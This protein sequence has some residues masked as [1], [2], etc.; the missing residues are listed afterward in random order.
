MSSSGIGSDRPAQPVRPVEGAAT[1]T[2]APA[3]P[4]V[5]PPREPPSR[6]PRPVPSSQSGARGLSLRLESL[7]VRVLLTIGIVAIGVALGAILV[8]QDVAGWITGLVV[9]GVSVLLSSILWSS[10][11]R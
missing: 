5:A 6:R 1:R 3:T 2:D 4:P 10:R 7:L 9:A 8:S 11:R